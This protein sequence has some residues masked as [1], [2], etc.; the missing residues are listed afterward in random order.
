MKAKMAGSIRLS[1][2][3]ELSRLNKVVYGRPKL[4]TRGSKKAYKSSLKAPKAIKF[5]F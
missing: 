5:K 4:A 1:T 2:P 3:Q